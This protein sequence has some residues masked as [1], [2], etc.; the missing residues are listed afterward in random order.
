[1]GAQI[2]SV[3]GKWEEKSRIFS[4]DLAALL[5]RMKVQLKVGLPT[6]AGFAATIGVRRSAQVKLDYGGCQGEPLDA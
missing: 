5:A 4:L 3:H 6:F 1:M 2:Q